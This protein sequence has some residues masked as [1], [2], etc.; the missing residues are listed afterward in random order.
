MKSI[1]FN[2]RNF[3]CLILL[4]SGLTASAQLT[5]TLQ[6]SS[7][8]LCEG[9]NVTIGID[10]SNGT[11]PYTVTYDDGN[12]I[13]TATGSTSPMMISVFQPVAGN[14]TY[15]IISVEDANGEVYTLNQP[16]QFIVGQTPLVQT[17]PPQTGCVGQM[18]TLTATGAATYNWSGN[19]FLNGNVFY[20][21]AAGTYT[22]T[23]T[24]TSTMGC[25]GV[26]QAIITILPGP[27]MNPPTAAIDSAYCNDGAISLTIP[28][29]LMY[30]VSW[31]NLGSTVPYVTGL[32]AGNYTATI[33]DTNGCTFSQT[34]NVPQSLLPSNCGTIKGSVQYDM[35]AN[36]QINSGDLPSVN[37]IV[38]ANP[39]NYIAFTDQAGNYELHLNAGSYA[40][41]E[42]INHPNVGPNCE[43]EYTVALA[44]GQTVEDIDFLDTVSEHTDLFAYG[45]NTPI[46][47]GFDF[48]FAPSITN[49]LPL[50]ELNDVDAWFTIPAGI[51]LIN[52]S[53]PHTVSN[54][55]VYFHVAGPSFSPTS[56]NLHT[57][58]S[59]PLGQI[60]TFCIGA[61]TS[62]PDIDLSN[63]TACVSSA[64]IGSYDP[65]DKTTFVSGAPTNSMITIQDQVLDYVIRFQNTGTADA[66]NI[67][68][69]DTIQSTLDITAF[70]LLNTSHHCELSV[71]ENNVLKFDFPSIHLPDSNTNEPLS[72]G[73]IHYRIRQ[74]QANY[75]GTE[76][77]N[78][79]YIYF[80]FNEAVI[81]NTTND[82]I[83]E[84]F[85][86]NEN[87][88]E[89]QVAVYPNPVN[90]LLN[91]QSASEIRSVK[92]YTASG[93][94]LSEQ[95]VS[96]NHSKIDLSAYDKGIYLLYVE[97]A[98]GVSVKKVQKL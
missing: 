42:V 79:A 65:N 23:V 51:T 47:P 93:H 27:E 75:Y 58:Q 9:T 31:G 55:T 57:D 17:N 18:F 82:L 15:N 91:V 36:C 11:A 16:Y 76:I 63:N 38:V 20:A 77:K 84:P 3:L 87:S 54:D 7:T 53:Y 62:E 66:I 71:L 21:S 48:N 46:R 70:Q 98:N 34:Y 8:V 44:A 49:L 50:F 59:V 60:I 73:Y 86:L 33:T 12:A 10:I 35:D 97:T 29:Q 43:D 45:Y 80:D 30:S 83:L 94:L 24:G 32:P 40:V 19:Q 56:V 68:V 2:A 39:G 28:G 88:P 92:I 25:T 14:F 64:V 81:T 95:S 13:Q 90:S 22:F 41:H 5:A 1:L 37:K 6:N 69:L 74:N 72:H 26:A 89:S 67:T 85:G 96:A 78:T 4:F 61:T 52:W